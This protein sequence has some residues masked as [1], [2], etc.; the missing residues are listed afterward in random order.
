MKSFISL[1]KLIYA[2]SVLLIL[3]P[4]S[5]FAWSQQAQCG[6]VNGSLN[7]LT[8][9]LLSIKALRTTGVSL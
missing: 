3:I 8:L 9:N 1:G 4:D 7:V 2:F 5:S 6:N